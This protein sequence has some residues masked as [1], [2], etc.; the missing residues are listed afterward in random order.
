MAS[1]LSCSPRARKGDPQ[2]PL[3]RSRTWRIPMHA[4]IRL[5]WSSLVK[6]I[7]LTG[8]LW[9]D[10][11]VSLIINAIIIWGTWGLL[12]DS[13]TMS[14]VRPIRCCKPQEV[15]AFLS[16]A[17][18]VQTNSRPAHLGDEHDGNGA[19][20]ASG[21]A[22]RPSRR[23]I[24]GRSVRKA[25]RGVLLGS[26][27]LHSKSKLIP[28]QSARS[29]SDPGWSEISL[30]SSAQIHKSSRGTIHSHHPRRLTAILR[31]PAIGRE[32]N[33]DFPQRDSAS[34]LVRL[35]PGKD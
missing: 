20:R 25:E 11:A 24:P 29:R 2:H 23:F 12:R 19:Y 16:A 1:A 18:G 14:L 31:T 32:P 34:S 7:L 3:A 10:P 22:G 28:T 13:V 15:R 30:S 26:V 6:I 33:G 35:G 5:A 4:C 17:S 8:W 21:D 27:T 9:L